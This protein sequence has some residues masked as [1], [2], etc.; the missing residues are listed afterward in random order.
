MGKPDTNRTG[1]HVAAQVAATWASLDAADRAG[2][3]AEAIQAQDKNFLEAWQEIQHVRDFVGAPEEILGSEKTKHGEIAEQVNVAFE[4][5]KDIMDNKAPAAT[6]KEGIGR[7]DP[8]DYRVDGVDIQSKYYN[9]LRNTLDGVIGHANKHPD[10]PKN[11]SLY[12]IPKDQYEQIE[13]LRETGHIDGLSD[14][15]ANTINRKLDEI[16]QSTGRSS[17]ELIQPGESTYAE[18]QQGKVHD[19]L[20]T[21]EN[22]LRQKN[23]ASKQELRAE[24]GPSWSGLGSA[25]AIGAAAGGGIR[26]TQAIWV[27]CREGKNPFKGE[28]STEDWKDVGVDAVKGVAGGGVAGGAL[29]VLTNSTD[30]AAPLAGAFVSSLM[31]VGVLLRQY[32]SGQINGDQFVES[33]HLVA[34]DAAI[35]GLV[36]TAGQVLIPVPLLGALLGSVAGK[37]VTSAIKDTLGEE[38][39]ELL[40]RLIAYEKSVVETLD[41]ELQQY[42]Q[43]LDAYFGNLDRI[44]QIAFDNTVNTRLRL[45]ASVRFA[46]S[47][48]VADHLVLRTTTDLDAFM[49]EVKP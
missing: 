26:L 49:H 46:G 21:R 35:V 10:F 34:T 25:A 28:F 4:R 7:F 33:S 37:I 6:L 45:E 32:H 47:V 39:S 1:P 5:I 27:K 29:Y 23:D 2:E 24:H 48:G 18:V 16:Q 41:D 9:G 13:Q 3:L 44:A 38:E 8:V 14:K 12:H 17:D 40:A 36:A 15:S 43:R 30:L 22:T 42:I 11:D 31:G 20:D 19:T